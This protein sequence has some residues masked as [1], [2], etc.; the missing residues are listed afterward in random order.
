MNKGIEREGGHIGKGRL[1]S[2]CGRSGVE[3]G[4]PL[5]V[6]NGDVLGKSNLRAVWRMG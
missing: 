2:N 1:R 4:N 5:K 3:T 6:S